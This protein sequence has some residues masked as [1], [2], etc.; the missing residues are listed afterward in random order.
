MNL[1]ANRAQRCFVGLCALLSSLPP[2]AGCRLSLNSPLLLSSALFS[3]V[4]GWDL[5]ACAGDGFYTCAGLLADNQQLIFG[6]RTAE[7]AIFDTVVGLL[8]TLERTA[9]RL[10]GPPG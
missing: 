9:V 1:R 3:D 7:Q 6:G 10:G 2:L 4:G 5:S 8:S